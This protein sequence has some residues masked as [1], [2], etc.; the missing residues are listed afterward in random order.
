MDE[1][2]PEEMFTVAVRVRDEGLIAL[3]NAHEEHMRNINAWHDATELLR[4]TPP[5]HPLH[6]AAE[7]NYSDAV[8]ECAN[9][10]AL[11]SLEESKLGRADAELK[12]DTQHQERR[13][14]GRVDEANI[15][16]D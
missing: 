11:V 2:K 6:K 15:A 14:G 4:Q 5:G 9:A 10:A 3:R 8:R 16:T 13:N 7:R 12:S 1:S